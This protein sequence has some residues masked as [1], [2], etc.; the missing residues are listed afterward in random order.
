MKKLIP[1][2]LSIIVFLTQSCEKDEYDDDQY[3]T[4]CFIGSLS[5]NNGPTTTFEYD[6]YD[7]ISSIS[8]TGEGMPNSKVDF[9]YN[10]N[11]SFADFYMDN[12]PL[13]HSEATLDSFNN[14]ISIQY[15][16]ASGEEAG[17]VNYSYNADHKPVSVSAYDFSLAKVETMNIEWKDGNA[18]RFVSGFNDH[19]CEYNKGQKSTLK[20]GKGNVF[21]Q[22]QFVDAN[23]G[24]FLSEDQMVTYNSK[25][26]FGDTMNLTYDVDS[27]GK[28]RKIFWST[29]STNDF[30]TTEVE[31]DCHN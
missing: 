23:I 24:L 6:Q 8:T 20:I 13:G 9:T 10:N 7:M 11:I 31:Y 29:T 26:Q 28:I 19:Q 16:W 27:D 4:T 3:G 5:I 15:T 17:E 14:V 12:Q 2:L 21:L 18:T 22:A 30:G 25:S 1:V